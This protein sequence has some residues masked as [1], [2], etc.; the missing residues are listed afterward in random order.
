L[1]RLAAEAEPLRAVIDPDHPSLLA[2]EDMPKAIRELCAATAQPVPEGIGATIRCCLDSLGLKYRLVLKM[3]EHITG[4]KVHTLHIVGGGSQNYLLNQ[5][6]ADATGCV[7]KAGPVEATATGN[8]LLQA[9]A[10]GELTG[11]ADLRR[12]VRASAHIVTFEPDPAMRERW[13]EVA[14]SMTGIS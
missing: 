1:T 5:I 14:D 7:V 9:R 6:A 4:Q 2:P 8:I 13:N 10:H 3:L 12:V 11:L